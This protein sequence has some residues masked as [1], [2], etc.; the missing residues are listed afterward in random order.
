MKTHLHIVRIVRTQAIDGPYRGIACRIMVFPIL[1]LLAACQDRLPTDWTQPEESL[2]DNAFVLEGNG[3]RHRVYNL[4]PM[5]ARMH[6]FADDRYTS[7]WNADSLFD[8]DGRKVYVAMQLTFPGDAEGVFAWEDALIN[9]SGRSTVRLYIEAEHWVSTSVGST[10]VHIDSTT[11]DK[12]M[13]GSFEGLLQGESNNTVVI[14]RGVF[15]GPM[16]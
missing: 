16:F 15:N 2:S 5:S 14:V 8:A 1:L 7:I 6:Y 11:Q 4:R 12:R 9:P 3:Y 13:H 10:T